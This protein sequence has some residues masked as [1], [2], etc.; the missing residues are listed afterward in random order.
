MVDQSLDNNTREQR[1]DGQVRAK[2]PYRRPVLTKLGTLRD[3]TM[4]LAGGGS[5][6]GMPSRGTKRGGDFESCEI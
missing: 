6:D 1:D 5:P 3:M 4:G 2:K